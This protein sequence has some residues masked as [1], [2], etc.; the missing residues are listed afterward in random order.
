MNIFSINQAATFKNMTTFFVNRGL[1]GG[2]NQPAENMT[3]LL[4]NSG[5]KVKFLFSC[6]VKNVFTNNVFIVC[7]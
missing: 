1:T 6:I 7:Y 5:E 4:I 2:S 3:F